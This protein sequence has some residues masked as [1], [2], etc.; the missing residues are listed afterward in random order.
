MAVINMLVTSMLVSRPC[1]ISRKYR[2]SARLLSEYS[3]A[4]SKQLMWT[5]DDVVWVLMSRVEFIQPWNI[6]LHLGTK[7]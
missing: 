2:F 4:S 7:T 1:R 5:Q 3:Q 6:E